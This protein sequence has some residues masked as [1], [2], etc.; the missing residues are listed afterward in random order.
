VVFTEIIFLP[1]L[2]VTYLCFFA[3]RHSPRGQVW[4]LLLASCVFYSWWNAK[5]LAVVL[6]SPAL[7]YFVVKRLW[8]ETSDARRRLLLSV[9]LA[10]NLSVL[11][12]FKYAQFFAE[13]ASA[14]AG[15]LGLSV[16]VPVVHVLLPIGISFHT[17]Q[18]MSYT[19]D[20]YRRELEPASAP[21]RYFLS[22]LA[23]PQLVAGP[24]VR[25]KDFLAQLDG[26]LFA[27]SS[28]DGLFL[29]LYGVAKKVLVADTLGFHVVDRVFAAPG[30][31]T[32]LDLVF[33]SYCYA[34]QIFFDF[35]GYSDIAIGL[36]LLFGLRFKPNFLTPYAAA[37]PSEFWQRWHI[38]LSTWLRD[39]LYIPLGGNR[40]GPWRTARNLM[41][42]MVLGG[43]WHGANWTFVVWGALHGIYL[44]ASR[45]LG[46]RLPF[47]VPRP[48]RVVLFFNLVCLTW[49]F[50]RSVSLAAAMGY[51][52]G[53]A[54]L[55]SGFT[56]GLGTVLLLVA[57]AA[58]HFLMEPDLPRAQRWFAARAWPVQAGATYLLLV[59]I[60]LL[61]RSGVVHAAFIYF[62]F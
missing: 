16:A 31:F 26:N 25:A 33:A 49:V 20:V 3:L 15:A 53:I 29:I 54:A 28:S 19:I 27:Q 18:A 1:F 46:D 36:G 23:F 50:F 8:R 22:V 56:L 38:S 61:D 5:Y 44:V 2:V 34:F 30:A 58:L 37:D 45:F 17:F 59:V 47:A 32:S 35:S 43:L 6:F 39:Y 10:T 14:L 12:V 57:S 9:S 55:T 21:E 4:L 40:G 24:I 7:D 41:I 62:Q 11:F 42:T 48:L 13:S 52:G 51:L 60:G